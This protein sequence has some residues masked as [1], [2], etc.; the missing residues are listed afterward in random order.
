L[1][2]TLLVVGAGPAAAG[3]A[4]AAT[5]RPDVEV[6]VI[7]VGAQLERPNADARMRMATSE[8]GMWDPSDTLT[9]SALPEDSGVKGLPEKRAYGSNFPFR[10]FGQRAGIDAAP[11]VNDALV[12][13][14]YG[15]FSTVW[16]AQVMPFTE[17]TFGAWPI[18]APEMRRHY[19][20]ILDRIPYAAEHDDLARL[21]PIVGGNDP[22]PPLSDRSTAVLDR[23]ARHRDR[24]NARGVLIGRARLAMDAPSCVRAG[25]CMTGCPYSLVYSA[26]HTLDELRDRGALKYHRGLLAVR[27][28]EDESGATVVAREL[29]SGRL[30]RFTADRVLLA[31]GAVG[32]S[33]LVM[34]SLDLFDITA[35]VAESMQFML[36]FASVRPVGDPRERRDFTLNQFNVAVTLDEAG[37]DVSLLHF[38]TYNP[39]FLEALPGFLRTTWA[40]RPGAQLLRRLSVALGYLPSW[41]SPSFD[42]RVQA[43]RDE[44][45]LPPLLVRG[46]RHA[47]YP[48]TMLRRVLRRIAAAARALD[49]WP[50]VPMLRISASGKSYHWGA[51][52]PHS[53]RPSGRFASDTLGRVAPWKRIHL[54]D[55]SVFPT[56]PATTF[57]LTIMANA[58]RIASEAVAEPR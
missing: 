57:T 19:A 12:S 7:D 20:A 48:S 27:V 40:E 29:A 38:Y 1:S 34:G 26:S 16:G 35:R 22:L 10:D 21:F 14:A 18:P 15:G 28:D 11:T 37:Y 43:R 8:P 23:Y 47:P 6:S 4:L 33:R 5:A 30:Q 51:V 42:I 36:P 9:V 45:E 25:L 41:R 50:V 32:T 2:Q 58:H 52:F 53:D 49:L 46:E 56:V 17:A 44:A 54:V 39:A 55:A 31:C 3:A 13:G 24:I